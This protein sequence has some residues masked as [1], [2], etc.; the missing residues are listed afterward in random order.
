MKM[1]GTSDPVQLGQART[2]RCGT[3]SGS[4]K[5]LSLTSLLGPDALLRMDLSGRMSEQN[6]NEH[7]RSEPNATQATATPFTVQKLKFPTPHTAGPASNSSLQAPFST[8][9]ERHS[10]KI[11]DRY[12]L[13]HAM[14]CRP[15]MGP[16]G[17]SSQIAV[18]AL[19]QRTSSVRADGS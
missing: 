5:V 11:S 19:L 13:H 3:A 17:S 6:Q 1:S 8:R 7:I 4:S 12:G 15:S 9:K 10:S 14:P 18:R 16:E 2:R